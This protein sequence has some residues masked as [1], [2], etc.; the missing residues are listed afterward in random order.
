MVRLTVPLA[1]LAIKA[2]HFNLDP[3]IFHPLH[4]T[5]HST[6]WALFERLMWRLPGWNHRAAVAL[7][8]DKVSVADLFGDVID[9]SGEGLAGL[10]LPAIKVRLRASPRLFLSVYCRV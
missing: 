8:C 3:N 9:M 5:D 6:G 7:G 2:T 1:Y 4:A 10:C